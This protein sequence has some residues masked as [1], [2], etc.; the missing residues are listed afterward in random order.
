MQYLGGKSKIRKQVASFLEEVRTGLPY[1]EPFVGGGWILQEM[2]GERYASDGNVA[3]ITMYQALQ[4]GWKPPE[5]VS[6][7]EYQQVKSEQNMTDPITA[8]CGFGCSFGGKWMGGYARSE[9]KDCYAATTKRS[10]S[11]QLPM[12]QDVRFTAGDYR[13]HSP[14]NM[15]VYCDPPYAN[16]TSYGAF[17]GFDHDEF[18]EVV[19]GWC[20]TNTVVVS[21]YSAPS[22]FDCVR[23]FN[24]RMGMTVSQERPVREERVFMHKSQSMIAFPEWLRVENYG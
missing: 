13:Q 19:R 23:V 18:W 21:E 10:L 20:K 7:D 6:E 24:S 17:D 16:T 8:F 2:S 1:F 4:L 9:G 22:D 11:K 12:I 14:K 3:L 5:F 15:L